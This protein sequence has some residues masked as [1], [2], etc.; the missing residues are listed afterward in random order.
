MKIGI[1]EK[2]WNLKPEIPE[3]QELVIAHGTQGVHLVL[4][5]SSAIQN[6]TAIA[7]SN[8]KTTC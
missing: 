3:S 2:L 1:P 7:K 6:P 5:R 4:M 8:K